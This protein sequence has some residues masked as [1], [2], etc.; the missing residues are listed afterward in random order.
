K[1]VITVPTVPAV[2]ATSAAGATVNYTA[3]TATDIVDG[4][5]AITCSANSGDTFP[6]GTTEVDCSA[7]DAHA[8][9]G[10]ASFD[11]TVQDSTAPAITLPSV[12]PFE[13]TGP[14]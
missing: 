7:T 13:A 1:P 11:V 4:T 8:N 10:T 9:T 14:A 6:I 3:P 2:E 5:D 12:A